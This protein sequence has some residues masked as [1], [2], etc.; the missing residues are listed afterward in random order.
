MAIQLDAQIFYH[1]QAIPMAHV[2]VRYERTMIDGPIHIRME[3]LLVPQE[4]P[5]DAVPTLQEGDRNQETLT[6][7]GWSLQAGWKPAGGETSCCP[8]TSRS[9]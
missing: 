2:E 3:G 9:E 8:D 7:E 1:G 4:G 6:A 5:I